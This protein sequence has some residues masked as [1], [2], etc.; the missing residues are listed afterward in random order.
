METYDINKAVEAQKK[1]REENELPNFAGNGVCFRCG[2][3]V[4]DE[5]GY[6]V[7][8][9]SERLVTGCPYCYRSFCD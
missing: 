8:Y 2:R 6:S 4:Y 5:G 1:F 7:E 3:N 9:A